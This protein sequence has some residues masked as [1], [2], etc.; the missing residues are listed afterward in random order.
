MARNHARALRLLSLLM[1]DGELQSRHIMGGTGWS[2]GQVYKAAQTLRDMITDMGLGDVMTVTCDPFGQGQWWYALR[3]GA[4]VHNRSA[5]KW[6]PNRIKDLRRR[7]KTIRSVCK[8]AVLAT[9]G[10]TEDGR[11]AR[12]ILE[13][14][15]LAEQKIAELTDDDNAA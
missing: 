5:T 11:V 15:E 8:A 6:V 10:R 14:L 3:R 2:Q 1:E 7:L 9:D 13:C 4:A 12:I